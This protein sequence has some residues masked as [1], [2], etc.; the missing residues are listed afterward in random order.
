MYIEG[1]ELQCHELKVD[2]IT[3]GAVTNL[4][5]QNVWLGLVS[6][7]AIIALAVVSLMSMNSLKGLKKK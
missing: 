4:N 3:G 5:D 7:V 1:Y 2:A 6:I